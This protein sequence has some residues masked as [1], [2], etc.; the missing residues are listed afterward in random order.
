MTTFVIPV[1]NKAERTVATGSP[2][3]SRACKDRYV[4]EQLVP[5]ERVPGGP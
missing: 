5:V 1:P 4:R 3:T 2:R